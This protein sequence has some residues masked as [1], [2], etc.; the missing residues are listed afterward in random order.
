MIAA[1]LVKEL[2]ERSGAGFMDCKNALNE[3]NGNIEKAIEFLR[4]SGAAK[5]QKKAGRS[6]KEGA[7]VQYIHPGGQLGVLVEVNCETDF[8]AR[9]DGF[10]DFTKDLAM[11]IAAA[12]P[13]V[14][15]R[16]EMDQTIIE[17]ERNFLIEQA[18]ESGK[19]ENIIEKMVDGRI[20]KFYAENVLLEQPF[21][22]DPEKTIKDL[23]T[24][25]V[26]TVGEN[27]SI[28]RFSR[29]QLGEYSASDK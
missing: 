7:V 20:E 8:V 22:K 23:M 26:A 13:M 16:E 15:S 29:F 28:A 5:A 18:K 4:K 3:T 17:K 12:S 21:V 6:T 2:R 27:I 11:H 1:S 14:V 24:E 10:R 9:T 25:V 19:P